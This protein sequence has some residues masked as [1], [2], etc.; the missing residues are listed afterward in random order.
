M[1]GRG[2]FR[3]RIFILE[4][5]NGPSDSRRPE[6]ESWWKLALWTMVYMEQEKYIYQ[7]IKN[8]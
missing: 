3:N 7:G 2:D 8:G 1:D 4:I 6:R 5:T